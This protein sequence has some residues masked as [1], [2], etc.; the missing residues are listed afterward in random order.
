MSPAIRSKSS[1]I[2]R[3]DSPNTVRGE[4]LLGKLV[5]NRIE[6]PRQSL[7]P[8]RAAI[9]FLS[10]NIDGKERRFQVADAADNVK[11]GVE[12][13]RQVLLDFREVGVHV[14]DDRTLEIRLTNP[15]PYF[16][17]LLGLLS[18]RARA[19]GLFGKVWLARLGRNRKTL[20][21]T[22]RSDS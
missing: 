9:A 10:S 8:P 18:F 21:P 7:I 15:T 17:D 2:R 22:A 12:H 13:C 1:S 19:P 11:S 14:I 3:I 20:S 5:A 4:L 6:R 16:L